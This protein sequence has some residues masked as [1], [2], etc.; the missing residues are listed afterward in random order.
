MI[1]LLKTHIKNKDFDKVILLIQKHPEVLSSKDEQG[2]SGFMIIAYS[3][4]E[5]VFKLAITLKKK[6]TFYEAIVSGHIDHVKEFLNTPGFNTINTHSS[7]GFTPVSLASFFNQYKIALLLLDYG[8]NPNIAATNPSKVN[9]LHAAVA[10]ENYELCKILL[11]KGTIVNATQTQQV[12]ALHSAVHRGN[13]KLVKLLI[14]YGA[15]I[16]DTMDNGDSALSIAKK[17]KHKT[18]LEYLLSIK[19]H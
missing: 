7:D 5:E 2:S 1:S 12:T 18:I 6:F 9:A 17:E 13:L 3:G 4:Q 10:K 8:A 11:E 14:T 16:T 15:S 19:N